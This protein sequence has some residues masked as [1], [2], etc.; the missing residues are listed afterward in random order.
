MMLMSNYNIIILIILSSLYL[1]P[2]SNNGARCRIILYKKG[3]TKQQVDIMSPMELGG[4]KSK[5]YLEISPQGYMPCLSIQKK[6]NPYG[7][8]SLAESDTIARYLL[9]EYE[10]IGPSFLI[11]HP[12]SNQ[13]ARWHDQ[14]LTTVQGCLYKPSSRLPLGDYPDRKSAL[15][16]KI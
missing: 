8:T 2:V 15:A 14:Y 6:D 4:L 1:R 10:N 9:S 11:N 16:G 7:I 3:I 13:I 12:K 5:E